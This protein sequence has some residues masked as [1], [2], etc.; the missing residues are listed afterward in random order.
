MQLREGM[1]SNARA[2]LVGLGHLQVGFFF[3]DTVRLLCKPHEAAMLAVDTAAG[4]QGGFR[5][6]PG[7]EGL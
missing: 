2:A 4:W 6:L 7:I 3:A 5:I 1:A